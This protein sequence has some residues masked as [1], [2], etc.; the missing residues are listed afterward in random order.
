VAGCD[1]NRSQGPRG[2]DRKPA[3]PLRHKSPGAQ[4]GPGCP[5]TAHCHTVLV[6]VKEQAG[7]TMSSKTVSRITLCL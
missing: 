5:C 7:K 4:L 2:S 1:C 6:V 3:V